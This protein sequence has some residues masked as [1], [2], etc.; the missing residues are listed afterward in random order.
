M[1][2]KHKYDYKTQT[3]SIEKVDTEIEGDVLTQEK[4][5]TPDNSFYT[6]LQ[7][8]L[9]DNKRNITFNGIQNSEF[10][11]KCD[12]NAAVKTTYNT[13]GS[14]M[15]K[16]NVPIEENTAPNYLALITNSSLSGSSS[17]LLKILTQ[18]IQSDDML[19][20]YYW[21][22]KFEVV[23]GVPNI[24]IY[25][26]ITKTPYNLSTS[27]SRNMSYGTEDTNQLKKYVTDHEP[28]N[29]YPLLMNWNVGRKGWEDNDSALMK[30]ICNA[31][32]EKFNKLIDYIITND[33]TVA[34]ETFVKNYLIPLFSPGTFKTRLFDNPLTGAS[35]NRSYYNIYSHA[36]GTL[37]LPSL[38]NYIAD[39]TNKS[40]HALAYCGY[41]PKNSILYVSDSTTSAEVKM[42]SKLIAAED[43]NLT[44]QDVYLY[45]NQHAEFNINNGLDNIGTVNYPLSGN[46]TNETPTT[47][48][49][50]TKCAGQLLTD[51]IFIDIG[52]TK[53]RFPK[54]TTKITIHK[55]AADGKTSMGEQ[56]LS[57]VERYSF[58]N[59]VLINN[60]IGYTNLGVFKEVNPDN[61]VWVKEMRTTDIYVP[62]YYYVSLVTNVKYHNGFSEF[63]SK[64]GG[65]DSG[66]D[67][68]DTWKCGGFIGIGKKKQEMSWRR[69][70]V[71]SDGYID[72]VRVN[73]N[74]QSG[75]VNEFW[76]MLK[77]QIYYSSA[78]SDINNAN[79]KGYLDY[80][81]KGDAVIKWEALPVLDYFNMNDSRSYN[82]KTESVPGKRNGYMLNAPRGT[83]FY[84]NYNYHTEN[85]GGKCSPD[86]YNVQKKV[87]GQSMIS[88]NSASSF[89]YDKA[90]ALNQRDYVWQDGGGWLNPNIV[91]ATGNYPD[92][93]STK[94]FGSADVKTSNGVAEVQKHYYVKFPNVGFT[95]VYFKTTDSIGTKKWIKAQG[96]YN[97]NSAGNI[98]AT[99]NLPIW[100]TEDYTTDTSSA[101]FLRRQTPLITTRKT[102]REI[103]MFNENVFNYWMYVVTSNHGAQIILNDLRKYIKEHLDVILLNK[104][105]RVLRPVVNAYFPNDSSFGNRSFIN[106]PLGPPLVYVPKSTLIDTKYHYASYVMNSNEKYNKYSSTAGNVNIINNIVYLDD[107]TDDHKPTPNNYLDLLLAEIIRKSS[108]DDELTDDTY[109]SVLIP[110]SG[111]SVL[112]ILSSSITGLLDA[113]ATIVVDN[114]KNTDGYAYKKT[115]PKILLTFRP[116]SS[117]SDTV[118]AA[119]RSNY[120]YIA[121]VSVPYMTL[122][123]EKDAAYVQVRIETRTNSADYQETTKGEEQPASEPEGLKEAQEKAKGKDDTTDADKKQEDK[124]ATENPTDGKK[125]EEDKSEEEEKKEDTPATENPTNSPAES[126]RY[127]RYKERYDDPSTTPATDTPTTE[128]PTTPTTDENKTETPAATTPTTTNE[129]FT[130]KGKAPTKNVLYIYVSYMNNQDYL[131]FKKGD[132][133]TTSTDPDMRNE[134]NGRSN[135]M[136]VISY[137]GLD[138]M[139]P[140]TCLGIRELD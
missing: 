45:P 75:K 47:V 44:G 71:T 131:A 83:T 135:P 101:N 66:H 123:K 97:I 140:A 103:Y 26:V 55:T 13:A 5:N 86:V 21:T 132:A 117:D 56:D 33:I 102:T 35:F 51:S 118:I 78:C 16:L 70:G 89:D 138:S 1:T 128:N 137:R 114:W 8:A 18:F 109:F 38:V 119:L 99:G 139:F 29:D 68:N 30:E 107:A 9:N 120:H 63:D 92:I 48:S 32:A 39:K 12:D 24:N 52:K 41:V 82:R 7:S 43:K 94:D 108:I 25:D 115:I 31:Y 96:T 34:D 100:T 126:F 14:I 127:R 104:A 4:I 125:E 95:I 3:V 37:L 111:L 50:I 105:S 113:Q 60:I 112:D 74:I 69:G 49:N 81:N 65:R 61:G 27:D 15:M 58:Y 64:E 110:A 11:V 134:V 121:E 54:E 17:T 36:N 116:L 85:L 28:L 133:S 20:Y 87:E 136:A 73:D 6:L 79:N 88:D 90:N 129:G 76:D 80:V 53:P 98:D 67:Q 42:D 93:V 124:P 23:N 19:T 91:D 57:N 77:K 72:C 122:H 46:Y 40:Q 62:L 59:D 106:I 22:D 130:G 2:T 84:G 10:E